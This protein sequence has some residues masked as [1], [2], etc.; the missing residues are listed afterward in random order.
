VLPLVP[1]WLS[2]VSGSS[3][4]EEGQKKAKVFLRTLFFVLGFT[5]VF[6]C[7]GIIFSGS[8][9]LAFRHY[10]K[11]LTIIAGSIL[12]I[13]GLNITFNLIAFLNRD[14][15]IHIVKKPNNVIS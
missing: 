7:F 3:I 2:F 10:A 13:L 5:I 11:F 9:M 14:M 6:T 1:G 15:R 12:I 8:G 4:L